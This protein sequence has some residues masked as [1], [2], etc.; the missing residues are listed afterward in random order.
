MHPYSEYLQDYLLKQNGYDAETGKPARD[1]RLASWGKVLRKYW[2]DEIPQLINVFKGDMKLVGVRPVSKRYFQDIPP[3]LQSL[4]LTQ[5]PG[6]IP[7]YVA[8]NTKKS[9]E[10]VLEAEEKYLMLSKNKDNTDNK[11]HRSLMYKA[12]INIVFKGIRSA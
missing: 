8:F 3:H 10:D 4:R 12:V 7:P 5:K 6:C 9:K 2:L 1:F 11:I